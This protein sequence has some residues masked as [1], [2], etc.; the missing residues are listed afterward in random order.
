MDTDSFLH[1]KK[2]SQF[3]S[4]GLFEFPKSKKPLHLQIQS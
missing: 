2:K 1:L 4:I 3:A